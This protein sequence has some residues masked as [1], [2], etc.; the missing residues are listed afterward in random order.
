MTRDELAMRRQLLVASAQ[1]QRARLVLD[2]AAWRQRSAR[3]LAG[4]SSLVRHGPLLAAG[5]A[6]AA[7]LIALTRRGAAPAAPPAAAAESRQRFDWVRLAVQAWSLWR[8]WR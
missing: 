2:G 7:S 8:A 1:L 3:W 6:C 5:L 4:P